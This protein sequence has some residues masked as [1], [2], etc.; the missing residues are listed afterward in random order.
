MKISEIVELLE[1]TV[2]EDPSDG[3]MEFTNAFGADLMSDVLAFVR[4]DTLLLT[5]LVNPHVLRTADMMD[6]S[7]V[8]FVR[9]KVPTEEVINVA[10]ESGIAILCTKNTM[11]TACGKL[12]QAGLT[13]SAAIEK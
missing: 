6:I 5:G 1:A 3:A 12:Y 4:S 8:V 2:I 7:C 11:Y 9:G 10:K 13:G